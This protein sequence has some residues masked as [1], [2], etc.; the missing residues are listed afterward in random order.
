MTTK[1]ADLQ[2]PNE[3]R[4][5]YSTAL[6]SIIKEVSFELGSQLKD[7]LL[8]LARQILGTGEGRYNKIQELLVEVLDAFILKWPTLLNK[9]DFPKMELARLLLNNV[10]GS[11]HL[12]K[13]TASSMCLGKLAG[14]MSQA[15]LELLL[16]KDGLVSYL[17][18]QRI[19][20]GA[21]KVAFS[22]LRLVLQSRNRELNKFAKELVDFLF[23]EVKAYKSDS[24]AET[25]VERLDLVCDILCHILQSILAVVESFPKEIQVQMINNSAYE[26]D[27]QELVSYSPGARI[28]Y[29]QNRVEAEDDDGDDSDGDEPEGSESYRVRQAGTVL[30]GAL[31]RLDP[32]LSDSFIHNGRLYERLLESK[33]EVR[34]A[35]FAAFEGLIHC[36]TVEE[37]TSKLDIENTELFPLK[38]ARTKFK[39]SSHQLLE[40]LVRTLS[41]LTSK[42]VIDEKS[43]LECAK[44]LAS[45]CRSLA[46][47]IAESPDVLNPVLALLERELKRTSRQP[48]AKTRIL[49]AFG[50]LFI[51]RVPP[52]RL[53]D[54]T[55]LMVQNIEKNSE[56]SL[57]ALRAIDNLLENHRTAF[58]PKSAAILSL[59]PV[60]VAELKVNTYKVE[61]RKAA[62]QCVS[63]LLS[64]Y[65]SYL[66]PPVATEIL[67]ELGSKLEG[68]TS[69]KSILVALTKLSPNL[70]LANEVV[71][72]L[73]R[74]LSVVMSSFLNHKD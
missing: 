69:K 41:E 51:K 46:G 57:A 5:I 56:V 8:D 22:T 54:Y 20:D 44:M 55:S 14:V 24:N 23:K 48:Q 43:T 59:V 52:S 13:S 58:G 18:D 40:R 35:A 39:G 64:E 53:G 72:A 27:I 34:E 61:T 45:I 16:Y 31:G 25:D 21:K 38:R 65:D 63:K 9:V 26:K 74:C 71:G 10:R 49:E 7:L 6:K 15:E 60:L 47:T 3:F 1:L 19:D 11:S 29:L 37:S 67:R 17:S 28:S 33:P 73:D 68:E 30:V 66:E 32:A 42:N 4:G 12:S 70:Q 36:I 2:T 62:V 50:S